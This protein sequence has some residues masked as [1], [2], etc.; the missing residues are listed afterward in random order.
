MIVNRISPTQ[1]QQIVEPG[2]SVEQHL[3]PYD[4][5]DRLRAFH[6]FL[7]VAWSMLRSGKVAYTIGVRSRQTTSLA[8]G[9]APAVHALTRS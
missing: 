1:I 9:D 6:M 7:K 5:P 8:E 3:G 4:W 2:E